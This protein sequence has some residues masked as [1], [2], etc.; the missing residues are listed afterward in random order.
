MFLKKTTKKNQT[1]HKTKQNKILKKK[2][3]I[4]TLVSNTTK[5][6]TYSSFSLSSPNPEANT[7]M[8]TF[9]QYQYGS[10][11]ATGETASLWQPPFASYCPPLG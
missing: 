8:E 9:D 6:F 2:K 11:V 7:P 4:I 1:N 3:H 10:G 5:A